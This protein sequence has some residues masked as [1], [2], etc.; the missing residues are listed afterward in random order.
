MLGWSGFGD[1]E[2]EALV[3]RISDRNEKPASQDAEDDRAEQISEAE[4]GCG[5]HG[6]S[7]DDTDSFGYLRTARR[8]LPLSVGAP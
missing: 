6:H 8:A 1:S 5:K 4:E 2:I 3:G 7:L